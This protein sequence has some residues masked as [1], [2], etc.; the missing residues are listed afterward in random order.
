MEKLEN[1]IKAETGIID[2]NI[3]SYEILPSPDQVLSEIPSSSKA[4]L[5]VINGRKDIKN[6]LDYTDSRKII[7]VGP[8]SIHDSIAARA[9]GEKLAE[10]AKEVKEQLVIVMRTYLEKPRS[11]I[12]WKGIIDDPALDNSNHVEEGI[13]IS[14]RLLLEINELG[15]PCANEFLR[16]DIPQYVS[17]LISW[18]AIGARTVESQTHRELASGLSMPIGFKNNTGGDIKV[19]VDAA[20]AARSTNTFLGITLEGKICSVRTKGNPYSHIV[21]R[22]GNGQPNYHPEKIKETSELMKQAKI[23][24]GIIVDCSHANSNKQYEEQ[25]KVAYEVLNQ[26]ENGTKEIVGIMIESNLYEGKQDFPKNKR[27]IQELKYG[28]SITDSCIGWETTERIIRKY[29]RVQEKPRHNLE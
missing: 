28:V 18:G 5:T 26:I 29:A 16:Q 24:A 27:E 22:G 19:A 3:E 13:K 20:I 9:Y 14:R 21:L 1:L 8:C 12:G 4:R 11:T 15:L 10:L 25:E 2:T 17:D 6:I 7:I 23:R